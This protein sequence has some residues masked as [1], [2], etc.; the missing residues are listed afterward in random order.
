MSQPLT[1]SI[2]VLTDS[3]VSFSRHILAEQG[4]GGEIVGLQPDTTENVLFA[5][6]PGRR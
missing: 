4:N 2:H 5:T 1:D 3:S 6:S